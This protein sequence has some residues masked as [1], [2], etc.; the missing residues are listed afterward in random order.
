M[1]K[2]TCGYSPPCICS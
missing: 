2:D 1:P